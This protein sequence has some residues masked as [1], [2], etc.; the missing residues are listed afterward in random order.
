MLDTAAPGFTGPQPGGVKLVA[1][2][3]ATNRVIKTVTFP[4]EVILPS[5]YAN[6]V[7]F[8]FRVG[9]EG[10]AYVT[11]SS[12][13]GPSGIIVLD[14]A[15]GHAV[16]RLGGDRSTLPDPNFRPVVEGRPV[17]I[18]TPA[19]EVSPWRVAADGIAL[20]ADGQ[21]LYFSPLSSRHLFSVPTRLLRDPDVSEATLSA[22]VIDLGEKGASDGL[23]ADADSAIYAGDY[24][25]N[26]IR[27]R[28]P[29]GHWE[30]LAY[31]PRLLWPDSLSIG[32]DGY[33]YFTVN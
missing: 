6:D 15:T 23:E 17:M 31:D 33:L 2:D 7:R 32:Q 22:A 30:T 21:T 26:G 16:R 14:L 4:A 12:A 8:D 24:E 13:Q 11:D 28:L 1:I 19:G 25:L 27:R 5:T 29:D 10:V 20:S 9:Q 18:R 3:L